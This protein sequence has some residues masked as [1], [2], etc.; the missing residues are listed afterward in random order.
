MPSSLRLLVFFVILA[1]A[2]AI[3]AG[4]VV[5]G[6]DEKQ[7][8][9]IAEQLTGGS[10]ASGKT[11]I[12]RYGCGGCHAIP[13]IAGADGQAG[14][15]LD[16]IA[17]QAELAGRLANTPGNMMLWIQHPQHVSPGN[18][19]P[20]TGVSDRDARDIAAYLYTLR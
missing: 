2:V 7:A 9:M 19:M 15:S 5:N 10:V 6:Q 16:K 8:R 12:Q 13:Q 4:V 17:T 1:A 18:A 20:E 11:S 14:P 3:V